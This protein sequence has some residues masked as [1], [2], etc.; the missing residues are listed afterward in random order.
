MEQRS[1]QPKN[2]PPP[3]KRQKL[4]FWCGAVSYRQNGKRP[5]EYPEPGL[6]L[7]EEGSDPSCRS[8]GTVQPSR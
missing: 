3:V 2:L 8:E 7:T 5:A 1:S 6:H 4:W